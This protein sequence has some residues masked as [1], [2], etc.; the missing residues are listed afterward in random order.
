MY[1]GLIGDA[2]A[3]CALIDPEA[4]AVETLPVR[5]ELTGYGRGQTIVDRRVAVGEDYIHGVDAGWTPVE[6]ALDVDADRM[7]RVFLATIGAE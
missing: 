2:G 3:V 6:V 7:A 5:V 1:S 4:L